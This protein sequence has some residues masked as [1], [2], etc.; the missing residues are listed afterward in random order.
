ML[1]MISSSLDQVS[2]VVLEGTPQ[3]DS[4]AP[5]GPGCCHPKN[6]R[7]TIGIT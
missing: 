7:I 5:T 4:P 6:G 2:I 1:A 3:E